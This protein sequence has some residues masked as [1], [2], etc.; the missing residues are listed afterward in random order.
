MF[1]NSSNFLNVATLDGGG[2]LAVFLYFF[3]MMVVFGLA[4]ARASTIPP[5]PAST[6][7]R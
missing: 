3:L 5:V 1:I 4:F 2:L 7:T 6:G